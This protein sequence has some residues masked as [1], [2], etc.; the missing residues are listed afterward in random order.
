MADSKL[1]F[2]MTEILERIEANHKIAME[3]LEKRLEPRKKRVENTVVFLSESHAA[4][5]RLREPHDFEHPHFRMEKDAV[6]DWRVLHEVVGPLEN[7]NV[8]PHGNDA[9]KRL[10]D[11]TLVPKDERFKHISFTYTRKLEKTD[12]CKLVRQK[13]DYVTVVCSN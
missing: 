7:Y 3:S 13:N 11:V 12:K 4:G 10:V 1:T 5:L 2:N 9:R 6:D 8:E